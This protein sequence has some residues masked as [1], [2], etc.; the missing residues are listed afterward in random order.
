MRSKCCCWPRLGWQSR[1]G[2][3]R[4]RR[5]FGDGFVCL[6][7]CFCLITSISRAVASEIAKSGSNPPETVLAAETNAKPMS[8]VDFQ[9]VNKGYRSGVREPLQSVV[10]NQAEWLELWRKHATDFNA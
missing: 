1:L 7:I 5:D 10:R 6:L 2:L 4:T 9:S 3:A 8:P